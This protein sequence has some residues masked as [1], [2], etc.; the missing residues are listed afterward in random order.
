MELRVWTECDD[1]LCNVQ[2]DGEQV[3]LFC[4]LEARSGIFHAPRSK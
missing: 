2:D 4:S 3:K 1:E